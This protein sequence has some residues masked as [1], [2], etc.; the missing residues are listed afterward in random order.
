MVSKKI[1]RGLRWTGAFILV[2]AAAGALFISNVSNHLHSCAVLTDTSSIPPALQGDAAQGVLRLPVKVCQPLQIWV[3][4]P[5]A[6][7][8][9]ILLLPDYKEIGLGGFGMKRIEEKLNERLSEFTD[10][11]REIRTSLSEATGITKDSEAGTIFK[12]TIRNVEL[13]VRTVQELLLRALASDPKDPS[14]SL[15]DAGRD[16]GRDWS[17]DFRKI[18]SE[19]DF[20]GKEGIHSALEDWSYY[21]GTAGMGRIY[22]TYDKESGL[23]TQA[24]FK[25]CFLSIERD[26]A[27]LRQVMAG[28]LAGSLDGLLSPQ[29]HHYR[30]TL[31]EKSVDRDL[32]KLEC[33]PDSS[34]TLL[35]YPVT[36]VSCRPMN[37]ATTGS[38][39]RRTS[40]S[41]SLAAELAQAALT[42]ATSGSIF[43]A[44]IMPLSLRLMVDS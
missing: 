22:F 10:E 35:C 28:Y 44:M 11:V 36:S 23:P 6:V 41:R 13:R 15:Y 3:V 33:E 8:A 26:N 39:N 12:G 19:V 7:L 2:V 18:E 38:T 17:R 25:S 40:S 9:L 30:V 27:D 31:E 32:Y 37:S 29:D 24:E 21:D 20:Q 14:K 42:K 1:L 5:L 16:W 34:A 43:S 4:L